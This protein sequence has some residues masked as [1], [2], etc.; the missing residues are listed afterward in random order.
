VNVPALRL[1]VNEI[2]GQLK[3]QRADFLGKS[4]P[5]LPR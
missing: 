3:A 4:L 2:R 1:Q 5:N